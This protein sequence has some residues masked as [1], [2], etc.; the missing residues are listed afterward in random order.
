MSKN[1]E[2]EFLFNSDKKQRL[3]HFLVEK[4]P[5]F[6]RSFI[7]NLIKN[8][9]VVVSGEIIK[10]SGYKLDSKAKIQVN[11]PEIVT[12]DLLP[13][14]I[15]LDVIFENKDVILIN[16][17]AGMVVHPSAGHESGTLVN[18]VLAHA[19]DIEGIG[20]EKRPGLV[21]RLD[22]D[23]SGLIILAKSD[24]ALQV[25][26]KQFKERTV[27]KRYLALVE[28]SPTTPN[29]KIETFIGRD[30]RVRQRMAVVPESRGKIAISEY[31]VLE[32]F[33]SHSLLEVTIFTG[34]THQIRVQMAFIG[35]SIV[36]DRVYGRK[37]P[38]LPLKRQ[39]LHAAEL[40]ITLP[41]K[42]KQQAFT[43]ELPSNLQIILDELRS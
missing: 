15:P 5:E 7:Q 38:S 9:S 13:E 14:N 40:E 32:K 4:M 33:E 17:E 3:D 11:V 8:E 23:T 22:K 31:K 36:G 12:T 34:R 42:D 19:A 37:R 43:A 21:H 16:K 24:N 20:G 35:S 18:A 41:G 10:K 29:G 28:G 26:Q 30:P 6:T 39:F 1:K 25:L 2:L 27:I